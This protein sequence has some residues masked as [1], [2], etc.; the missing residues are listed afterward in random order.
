[1]DPWQLKVQYMV[2]EAQRRGIEEQ[3][4]VLAE[5]NCGQCGGTGQI[6][7]NTEGSTTVGVS[8]STCKI[9]EGIGKG[10]GSLFRGW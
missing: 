7:T 2:L 1:M 8:S 9:C 6:M 10:I 4:K 5:I 3:M